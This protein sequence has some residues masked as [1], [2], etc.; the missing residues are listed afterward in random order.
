MEHFGTDDPSSVAAPAFS[1][2]KSRLQ[3]ADIHKAEAQAAELEAQKQREAQAEVDRLSEEKNKAE[4]STKAA[5]D[6]AKKK[7]K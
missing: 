4:E 7:R 1:K 6:T 3:Q 2:L 5:N